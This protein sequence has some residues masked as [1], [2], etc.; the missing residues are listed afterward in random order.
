MLHTLRASLLCFALL[1]N[2]MSALAQGQSGPAAAIRAREYAR[3]S[4]GASIKLRRE[5]GIADCGLRIYEFA[6]PRTRN[7]D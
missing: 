7:R 3:A 6:Q 5:I 2:P 1:I 4:S